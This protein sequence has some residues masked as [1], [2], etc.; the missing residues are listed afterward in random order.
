M[1]EHSL[2]CF[3]VIVAV[4]IIFFVDI[5]KRR[6]QVGLKPPGFPHRRETWHFVSDST[7]LLCHLQHLPKFV[8]YS[9]ITRIPDS[10]GCSR[11]QV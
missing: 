7:S 10:R 9:Q 8:T 5:Y 6:A 3:Q 4:Q 11:V 2:L 1:R